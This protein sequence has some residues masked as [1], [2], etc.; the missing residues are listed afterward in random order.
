MFFCRRAAANRKNSIPWLAIHS[1]APNAPGLSP[2]LEDPTRRPE[3]N[4]RS[5][6][7]T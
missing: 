7:A 2:R 4:H 1:A 3:R 5:H 6:L